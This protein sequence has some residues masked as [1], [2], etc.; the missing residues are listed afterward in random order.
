MIRRLDTITLTSLNCLALVAACALLRPSS[1]SAN[2]NAPVIWYDGQTSHAVW[3]IQMVFKNCA[4]HDMPADSEYGP[5]TRQAVIDIQ[6]LFH[7][8]EDG[9]VG[10]DTGE[11][12]RYVGNNCMLPEFGR[13]PYWDVILSP[14]GCDNDVPTQH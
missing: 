14:E 13:S 12:I 9:E 4:G 11:A 10:R 3:C 6:R 8:A 5:I 1:A 7:L 2:P